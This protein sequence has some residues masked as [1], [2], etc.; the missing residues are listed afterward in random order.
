MKKLL[1]LFS[2]IAIL[3]G[4][5]QGPDNIVKVTGTVMN[6][7]S[8]DLIFYIDRV[9]D[10]VALADDGSFVFEKETEKPI[11][12]MIL[13]G[14]KRATIWMAPGKSLDVAVDVADWDNSLGFSGDL[15][16]VNEYLV[17]KGNIQMG[18]SKDYMANYLS[19]PD[20]F[21]SRR[22]SVQQVFVDLFD[23]YKSNGMDQQFSDREEIALRYTMYGDLNNYPN[24]HKYYAKLD[25]VI[26]PDD[27][28]SFTSDMDL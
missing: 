14:R 12:A 24:A 17:E 27:W 1:V 10:T 9:R 8:S 28:Y 16:L 3:A 4:C 11:T 2:A 20:V 13:Y 22:D 7:D 26:L 5:Q 25:S 19:E 6:P 18:W 21:R 23:E 15:Q